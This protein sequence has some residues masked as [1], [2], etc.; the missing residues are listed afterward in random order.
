MSTPL[1]SGL[2]ATGQTEWLACELE[3]IAGRL[4][5]VFGDDNLPDLAAATTAFEDIADVAPPAAAELRRLDAVVAEQRD[6]IARLA[7]VQMDVDATVRRAVEKALA[8]ER[9]RREL[10]GP[11]GQG[12]EWYW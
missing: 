12:V 6:A 5:E 4:G 7:V 1:K 10:P 2:L 9:A 8:E 11:G 3:R